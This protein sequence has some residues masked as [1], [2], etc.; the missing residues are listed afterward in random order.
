MDYSLSI[1]SLIKK[2]NDS[3]A[4]DQTEMDLDFKSCE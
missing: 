1:R 3:G 2:L 4:I